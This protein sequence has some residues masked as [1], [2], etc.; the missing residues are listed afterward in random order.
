M[1]TFT[2]VFVIIRE[3]SIGDKMREE[4]VSGDVGN[5]RQGCLKKDSEDA[6]RPSKRRR[7]EY[8]DEKPSKTKQ[9]GSGKR[10]RR[11]STSGKTPTGPKDKAKRSSTTGDEDA[12]RKKARVADAGSEGG[13]D[14]EK[15][16]EGGKAPNPLGSIIGRK[17]KERK[18]KGGKA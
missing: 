5:S 17:R 4:V 13:K 8:E 14:G 2:E 1:S 12:P 16:K 15:T 9:D 7:T 10:D 11:D 3:I 18:R 6:D